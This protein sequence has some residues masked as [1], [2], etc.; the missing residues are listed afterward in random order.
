MSAKISAYLKPDKPNVLVVHN[1]PRTQR[2]VHYVL[3]RDYE[4][5]HAYFGRA[6]LSLL[7][8][9]EFSLVVAS[10]DL[11]RP[12]KGAQMVKA[13]EAACE[14]IPVVGLSEKADA[15][16]AAQLRAAGITEHFTAPYPADT[17]CEAVHHLLPPPV[18]MVPSSAAV[19]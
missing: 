13:L 11:P 6:A 1:D 10:M 14:F 8:R 16:T 2:W 17:F 12:Y 7:K 15:E 18:A 3:A 4:I 9:Q 19:A 5:H